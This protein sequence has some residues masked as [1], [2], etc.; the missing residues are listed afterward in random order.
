M[1]GAA[2]GLE[3]LIGE[4]VGFA[5]RIERTHAAIDGIGAGGERGGEGRGPTRGGEQFR[6]GNV[7]RRTRSERCGRSGRSGRSG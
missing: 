1:S 2:G 6:S 5:T 3:G 4:V 7:A